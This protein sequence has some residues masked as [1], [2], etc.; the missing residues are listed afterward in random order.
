MKSRRVVDATM[1]PTTDPR[2]D[3]SVVLPVYNEEAIVD[4]LVDRLVSTLDGMNVAFELSFI[5]DGS[6]DRTVERVLARRARDPRVQLVRFSR[7]FGHHCALSAGIDHARGNAVVMMDSDLQDRPEE[8][9]Q[10]WEKYREGYDVVFAELDQRQESR[11]KAWLGVGFWRVFGWFTGI[12][13]KNPGVFRIVDRKVI[14]ALRQLP[15][16]NRFLAGLFSWVGFEQATV[17]IERAPRAAGTTHYS[18]GKQIR[19]SIHAITSFSRA[20]LRLATYTSGLLSLGALGLAAWSIYRKMMFGSANMGWASLMVAISVGFALVLLM[21]GIIG[22]YLANIL[23]EV[24]QRPLYIVSE[25]HGEVDGD[26]VRVDTPKTTA[27]VD[28]RESRKLVAPTDEFDRSAKDA[29][30]QSTSPPPFRAGNY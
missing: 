17:V 18:L 1:N 19:L 4:E 23:A 15:E 21:M 28:P 11:L 27:V 24:Q 5:D 26:D 12:K 22:E 3:I 20:P 6:N 2:P 10:L 29:K 16:R 13:L 9:P 14:L 30:K 25:T 8:I 7:N